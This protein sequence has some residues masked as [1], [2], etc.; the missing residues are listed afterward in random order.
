M[1]HL[2]NIFHKYYSSIYLKN[3][4]A[5]AGSE[6]IAQV[7]LIAVTPFLTRFYSPDEFGQ[8]EFYKSSALLLTVMGFLNYDVSIYT[9]KNKSELINS[10]ALSI[11]ILFVICCI[12]SVVLFFFNEFFV[13]FFE[14]EIKTGWFWSL[15][16]YAFFSSLTNLILM[17]L[18]KNG[19][20]RLLSKIKILVSIFVASTQ[21]FFGWLNWGYWG[22]VYSTIIVQ[23][24]AF[25]LYFKSFYREFK[26]N[27]HEFSFN[28]MEIILRTNWR[29]PLIVFPGNFLNNLVQSLPVF[30]LG[31]ID[32]Q[33]LGYY[34][35]A[36]RIIDFPLKFISSSVQRLYV[37]NLTDEI[38][39]TGTGVYSYV[40]HLKIYGFIAILL[41][42]GILVFTKPLLPF[43]FGNEWMPALPFI[44][45]LGIL[46]SV[47]FIFG[48][49]SFIMVL[50][51]AP[52]ID[53]LWQVLF[54]IT[55]SISF[56]ICGYLKLS[57]I[58]T[59]YIYVFSGVFSYMIYGLISYKVSK[60]KSMLSSII[61]L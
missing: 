43:F 56:L 48:G 50:G 46:F 8:Y 1:K 41:I 33:V 53:I 5:L 34:S 42:A 59:V 26:Q 32:S 24:F 11:L 21:L 40:K 19:A 15:P 20:F 49:L 9:S 23:I 61:K 36:R 17:V 25:S 37:K 38:E 29:L 16:L 22:L 6:V 55:I 7:I 2:R 60:S 44:L 31:R 47:R 28:G 14:S 18:T 27:L 13:D 52:A 35:L 12:A 4:T 3:F 54:A 30:F 57:P 51:K 10:L 45:A 58:I 39:R